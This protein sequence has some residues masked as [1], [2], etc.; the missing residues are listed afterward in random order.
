MKKLSLLIGGVLFA[1]ILSAQTINS[2]RPFTIEGQAALGGVVPGKKYAPALRLRYFFNDK[3]ALRGTFGLSSEIEEKTYF[4]FPETN[5][6]AT[7]TYRTQ[8]TSWNGSLGLEFH[9][10]GIVNRNGLKVVSP[11]FAVDLSYGQRNYV[12]DG[13]NATSVEFKNNYTLDLERGVNKISGA[14]FAGVDVNLSTRFYVGAEAGV[15][16]TMLNVEAGK[17]EVTYNGVTKTKVFEESKMVR[18]VDLQAA[19]RLGFRF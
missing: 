4:E 3:I 2:E 1:G 10:D 12:Y 17:A 7:G 16:Y 6:G 15:A 14:A 13:D 5:T 8:Q 11:Y 9:T 18:P 19:I